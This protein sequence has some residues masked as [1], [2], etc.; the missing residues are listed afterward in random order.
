MNGFA[1]AVTAFPNSFP[2]TA[3]IPPFVM[4]FCEAVRSV[5]A[6][7]K[8]FIAAPARLVPVASMDRVEKARPPAYDNAAVLK[9]CLRI[10]AELTTVFPTVPKL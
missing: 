4:A 2:P 9:P 8:L 3:L 6:Q 10:G 7:A 1:T 5:F